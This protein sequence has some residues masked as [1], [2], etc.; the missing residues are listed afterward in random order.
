MK[1]FGFL[2]LVSLA[3]D[4]IRS[5]PV[6]S[7]DD[8]DIADVNKDLNLVHGDIMIDQTNEKSESYQLVILVGHV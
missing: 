4:E 6:T 5:R 3:D 1:I 7:F 8:R 2:F